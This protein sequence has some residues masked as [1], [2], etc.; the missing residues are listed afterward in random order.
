MTP[1]VQFLGKEA[2]IAEN[3]GAFSPGPVHALPSTLSQTPAAVFREPATSAR[4][5]DAPRNPM[6]DRAWFLTGEEAL[7]PF[8][9]LV[10]THAPVIL[11][12][13]SRDH[14]ASI[15][16]K[17]IGSAQAT[18]RTHEDASPGPAH[19]DVTGNTFI[20]STFN[21]DLAQQV[22]QRAARPTSAQRGARKGG[23]ASFE[24]TE[25]QPARPRTNH[26]RAAAQLEAQD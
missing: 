16:K 13:A 5:E 15:H 3:L 21:K 23:P 22:H 17:R 8:S 9:R 7:V 19:Y 10:I 11:P 25:L 20:V 18:T 2:A 6:R 26:N 12:T 24:T 1:R 4:S 14:A